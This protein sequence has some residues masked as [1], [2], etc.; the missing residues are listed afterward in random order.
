[1]LL[2]VFDKFEGKY[3]KLSDWIHSVQ[4]LFQSN[5][6]ITKASIEASPKTQWDKYKRLVELVDFSTD[7]KSNAFVCKFKINTKLLDCG[8]STYEFTQNTVPSQ[9]KI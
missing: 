2:Q 5:N 9:F 6:S 4:S 1:M 7:K 3:I 8:D